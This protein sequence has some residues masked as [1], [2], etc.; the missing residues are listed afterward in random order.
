MTEQ[1]FVRDFSWPD[2]RFS[3]VRSGPHF[4]VTGTRFQVSNPCDKSGI[5][6]KPPIMAVS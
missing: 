6:S 4:F 2:T 1:A 5:V 3:P